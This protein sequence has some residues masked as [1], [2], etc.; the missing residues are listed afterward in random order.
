[1][2]ARKKKNKKFDRKKFMRDQR[3]IAQ[4][5]PSGKTVVIERRNGKLVK[6]VTKA[7]GAG[8]VTQRTTTSR[9]KKKSKNKAR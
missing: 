8:G 3:H 2:P 6:T 4:M 7:G 9:A 5:S 1:M